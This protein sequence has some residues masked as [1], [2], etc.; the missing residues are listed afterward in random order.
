MGAAAIFD[1][2]RSP[3]VKTKS[4]FDKLRNRFDELRRRLDSRQQIVAVMGLM[5][6]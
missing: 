4:P 1:E 6:F 3:S 5:M 2:L